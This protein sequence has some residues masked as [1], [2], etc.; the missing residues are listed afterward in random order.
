[1][2]TARITLVTVLGL[3]LL[4]GLVWFLGRDT[5]PPGSNDPEGEAPDVG[6]DGTRLV[7]PLML[8]LFPSVH[9]RLS[10]APCN[11]VPGDGF[12]SFITVK[13]VGERRMTRSVGLM[14]GDAIT[15]PGRLGGETMRRLYVD[16]ATDFG[17][18]VV[19]AGTGELQHGIGFARTVLSEIESPRIL[20]ANAVDANG[21]PLLHGRV[22]ARAAGAGTPAGDR[23]AV[24]VVAVAGRSIEPALRDAGSDVL[25]ESPSV[26]AA[27]AFEEGLA[28]A[29][30]LGIEV[31]M[32]VLLVHGT[33]EETAAIVR[34]VPGFRIAVAADG[35]LLPDREPTV[36]EETT[37]LYPG[38][39]AGFV[40]F[41][42]LSGRQPIDVE[43]RLARLGRDLLVRGDERR[44]DVLTL[45]RGITT[46]ARDA[47]GVG[48]DERPPTADGAYVGA[49]TCTTCHEDV[50]ARHARSPH[51][52]PPERYAA[53]GREA[54][55]ACA[56]CHTT[57]PG[58]RG[59][60]RGPSDTSDL[61]GVSCEAC[62]GP[63]EGHAAVPEPGWGKV[64]WTRCLECHR[65]DHSPG[66][67]PEEAWAR[68]GHGPE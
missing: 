25:I 5:G 43:P 33:R 10:A 17:V 66:F 38:G 54:S 29:R 27:R 21:S 28:E 49:E 23:G 8:H 61:R 63:G 18:N 59:G 13:N 45:E 34:D 14:M 48:E 11:L 4:V 32:T 37:V 7:P 30:D 41:V 47:M 57:A 24:L 50:A 3:A 52:A 56:K 42:P 44:F 40:W 36:V 20:C 62:H 31:D 65:P 51:F 58:R 19:A 55:P 2:S 1:M 12:A 64:E 6:G 9:D 15:V 53:D 67:D 35:P 68:L 39:A 60:W 46:I 26:F 16:L 22:F